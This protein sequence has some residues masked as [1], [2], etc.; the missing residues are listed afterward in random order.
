MPNGSFFPTGEENCTVTGYNPPNMSDG[1][2]CRIASEGN[3]STEKS[4]QDRIVFSPCQVRQDD[5]YFML[6]SFFSIFQDFGWY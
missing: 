1:A 3:D 4:K 6:L 2:V 5:V